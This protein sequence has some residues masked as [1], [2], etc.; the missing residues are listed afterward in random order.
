LIVLNKKK[1]ISLII[2]GIKLKI[3]A[4]SV[5]LNFKNTKTI[6]NKKKTSAILFIII[7]FSAALFANKRVNQKFI[8][9]YE[10]K[11]TP[12]QPTKTCIRLSEVTNNII[13]K[14]NK[15]K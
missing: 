10:H 3:I 5:V 15:D 2:Y 11:P 9:K 13:K 1:C 8:N 14:V 12:S 7:A 6:A 4:K